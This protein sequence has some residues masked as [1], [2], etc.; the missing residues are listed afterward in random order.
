[1]E[2]EEVNKIHKTHDMTMFYKL[3]EEKYGRKCLVCG[4]DIIYEWKNGN[5]VVKKNELKK[6]CKG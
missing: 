5:L 1:M 4:K 2:E 3:E 6:E